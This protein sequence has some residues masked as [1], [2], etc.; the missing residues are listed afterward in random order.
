MRNIGHVDEDV[1]GWV[2][3]Q[4]RTQPLLVKVVSDEADTASENEQTIERTDLDVL[5][6]LFRRECTR[7]AEQVN[8]AH[9]D[10][11]VDIQDE[12][13]LLR[14]GDLLDGKR[15]VEQRVR[16]EVLADVLRD[17][18]DA[19][20]GVVGALDLVAVTRDWTRRQSIITRKRE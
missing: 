10:T 8:E 13:V 18:L 6:C 12:R 14:G 19:E 2:T 16:R 20:I 3:V 5:V 1:V 4:R 11:A 15:V 17:E 9:R 7:I